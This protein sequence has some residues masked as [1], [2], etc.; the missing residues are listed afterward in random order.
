M[1]IRKIFQGHSIPFHSFDHHSDHVFMFITL[2]V[3]CTA[4]G[5]RI[6]Y[7]A[8]CHIVQLQPID[9]VCGAHSRTIF[10]EIVS[11]S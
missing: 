7:L 10:L 8:I 1:L 3:G 4:K 9:P 2:H 6:D 11:R 5:H